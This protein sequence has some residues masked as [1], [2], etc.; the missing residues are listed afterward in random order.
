MSKTKKETPSLAK[1]LAILLFILGP[2]AL[3]GTLISWTTGSIDLP[4]LLGSLVAIALLF[5]LGASL[6][7][8]ARTR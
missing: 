1:A 3:L 5:Y 2:L 8:S 7:F 4:Q 6:I